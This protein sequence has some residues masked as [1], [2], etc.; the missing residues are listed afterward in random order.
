MNV[1]IMTTLLYLGMTVSKSAS[2]QTVLIIVN[3]GMGTLSWRMDDLVMV[4]LSMT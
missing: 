3:V 2:T 1:T 4:R